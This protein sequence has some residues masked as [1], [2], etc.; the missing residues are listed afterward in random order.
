MGQ[1]GG[2]WGGGICL[3]FLI[4]LLNV[5]NLANAAISYVHERRL[6]VRGLRNSMEAGDETTKMFWS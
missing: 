4:S 2:V 3:N 1:L 5:L 6:Y